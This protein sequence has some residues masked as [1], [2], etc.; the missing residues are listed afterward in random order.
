MS[1]SI[2]MNHAY[3]HIVEHHTVQVGAASR[4]MRLER[5]VAD[6]HCK[7]AEVAAGLRNIA[8]A[9]SCSL[10]CILRCEN[11]SLAC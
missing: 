3:C 10:D 6:H 4:G 7:V 8:A 11:P 5:V 1:D 2:L 9:G